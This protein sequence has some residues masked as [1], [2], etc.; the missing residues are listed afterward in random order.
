MKYKSNILNNYYSISELIKFRWFS[1]IGW[2]MKKIPHKMINMPNKEYWFA[3]ERRE[4]SLSIIEKYFYW[5]GSIG[6]GVRDSKSR[7]L[8]QLAE[9]ENET[10]PAGGCPS[11]RGL[12]HVFHD[13]L[14]LLNLS[15]LT[16]AFLT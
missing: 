8:F 2:I 14:C 13:P 5:F 9:V 10:A 3:E 15:F 1:F 6:R 11:K 16:C 12:V 4:Q 7:C